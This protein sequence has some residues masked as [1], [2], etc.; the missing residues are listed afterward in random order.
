MNTIRSKGQMLSLDEARENGFTLIELMIVILIIAI[1]V[2]IAIPL[3]MSLSDRA[4]R[5]T[6]QANRRIGT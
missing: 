6:A 4:S 5:N 3:F 2:A 1:L